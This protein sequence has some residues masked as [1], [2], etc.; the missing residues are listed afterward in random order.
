MKNNDIEVLLN[1]FLK[2]EQSTFLELLEI[3]KDSINKYAKRYKFFFPN[4]SFDE[5]VEEGITGLYKAIHHWKKNKRKDFQKYS[6]AWIKKSMKSYVIEN[7]TLVKIPSYFFKKFKKILFFINKEEDIHKIAKKTKLDISEIKNILAIQPKK[8]I[9][10]DDYLDKEE[11]QETLYDILADHL[12]KSL[13]EN[14]LRKE[15]FD[16]LDNLL[17]NLTVQEKEILKW[18]FGLKDRK[19]H[20]IKE[21]A[22]KMNLSSQKVREIEKSALLKLKKIKLEEI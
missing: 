15:N 7:L 11:Q 18:R 19:H 21:I 12:S 13:D 20:T 4:L 16:Y 10:F 9:S 3:Y 14:I 17:N 8:D 5:L 22:K 2:G 1:K 6:L